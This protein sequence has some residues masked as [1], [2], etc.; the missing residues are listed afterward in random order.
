MTR[1]IG[2]LCAAG[3]IAAASPAYAQTSDAAETRQLRDT[4][5]QLQD[6]LQAVETE[7]AATRAAAASRTGPAVAATVPPAPA[8]AAS[9]PL[10]VAAA[11][12]TRQQAP[13]AAAP[14]QAASPASRPSKGFRVGQT[15]FTITGFIKADVLLSRYSGGP[16][17]TFPLG[18]D[19][20][21]PQSIP[22][23]GSQKGVDFDA[24]AKQTR[25]AFLTSTPIGDSDLT[26]VIE[27]D[28]QVASGTQGNERSLNAYN[29][30]L[31]RASLS[32]KGWTVGQDW[33]TFQYLPA[34]P[35]TADFL[36]VT[37]GTVFVRQMLARYARPLSD[38]LTVQVA[39]EN[40]ETTTI[41]AGAAVATDNNDDRMPDA[42]A[43]L[44]WKRGDTE[45]SLAGLIRQLRA[46]DITGNATA[47]GYGLSFAG[48]TPLPTGKGDDF[49]FML[50]GGN[51]IGRYI[52]VAFAP[53][54]V[55]SP[56][57]TELD[58]VKLISGFAAARHFWAPGVR[59]TVSA[60]FQDV[61]NPAGITSPFANRR[62]WSAGINL[63]VSPLPRLDLGAE[64]RHTERVLENGDS[65]ALDR[66]QFTVKQSF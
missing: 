58:T 31:R 47:T 53:D 44:L 51:G 11:E 30:G 29:L 10:R 3:L 9:S 35:E 61:D 8:A 63:F 49:R 5:K 13:S 39:L 20:A 37:E 41:D 12:V 28:F 17:A 42:I 36:G 26:T 24:H 27:A 33:S 54:A 14:V 55:Y 34:L 15:D 60:S 18:R 52:G 57:T 43:R 64:F 1:K 62:A 7:L 45:L 48:H 66:L 25:I 56:T 40:A 23:G 4:L 2:A 6:R 65:G 38:Q 50:T 16:T 21:V 59:S 46:D 22:V 32:Y 19:F